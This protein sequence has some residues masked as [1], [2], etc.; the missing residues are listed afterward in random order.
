MSLSCVDSVYF[1]LGVLGYWKSLSVLRHNLEVE[2]F[3]TIHYNSI[4][5]KGYQ[6]SLA[7]EK[8]SYHRGL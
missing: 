1:Y 6:F 7:S 5:I 8:N 3:N 2:I 4:H